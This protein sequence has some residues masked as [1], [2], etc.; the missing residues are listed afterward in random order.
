MHYGLLVYFFWVLDHAKDIAMEW[1][2]VLLE[3]KM[4][5]EISSVLQNSIEICKCVRQFCW[6]LLSH[7]IWVDR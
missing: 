3:S 2:I 4:M 5:T 6:I 1:L 7:L